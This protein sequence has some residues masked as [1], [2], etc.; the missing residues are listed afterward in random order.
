MRR[1]SFVAGSTFVALSPS[2]LICDVY[3]IRATGLKRCKSTCV[4][5]YAQLPCNIRFSKKLITLTQCAFLCPFIV[6]LVSATRINRVDV[7]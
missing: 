3:F 7:A 6:R 2:A 1:N 4:L 5:N